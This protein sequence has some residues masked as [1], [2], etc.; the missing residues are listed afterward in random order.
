MRTRTPTTTTDR[1]RW[2]LVIPSLLALVALVLAACGSAD[3]ADDA[4]EPTTDAAAETEDTDD[5]DEGDEADDPADA[6]DGADPAEPDDVSAER[7]SMSFSYFPAFHTMAVLYA[8]TAGYFEDENLEVELTQADSGGVQFTLVVSGEV[9]ASAI[10]LQNVARTYGE[11][12]ELVHVFPLVRALS[13]NLVASNEALEARG[14]TPDDPIEDRIA[15]LADM[16]IGFTTPNAPTEIFSRFLLTQAGVDPDREGE[17]VS[18]GSPPNLL[19]ALSS[20]QIDAFMLTPPTPNVP[21]IQGYGQLLIRPSIG[22]IEELSD[23]PY[24]GVVV[25][26]SWAEENEEALRRFIRAVLRANLEIGADPEASLEIMREWFPDMD[27]EVML[28]GIRDMAP[29]LHPDGVLTEEFVAEYLRI[30]DELGMLELDDIP[31][32]DEGALWTNAFLPDN[33]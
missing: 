14:I 21:E 20:G 1:R 30:T 5:G 33:G 4:S 23:F 17:L 29:A 27:Q 15:A 16:T 24:I 32:A 25:Q 9:D 26:K 10:E 2:R 7:L 31:P 28:A 18:V 12:R 11:S 22:E 8:E 3:D 13:M 19:A 6:D